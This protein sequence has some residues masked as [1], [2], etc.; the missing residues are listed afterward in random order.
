MSLL[1]RKTTRET[2]KRIID[3]L[4]DRTITYMEVARIV[5]CCDSTVK[6]IAVSAG[7]ARTAGHSRRPSA[8]AKALAERNKKVLDTIREN[9]ALNYKEIAKLIGCPFQSVQKLGKDNGLR[10]GGLANR[11]EIEAWM[12]EKYDGDRR[13]AAQRFGVSVQV[14]RAI[15]TK[16]DFT[17][18]P[19]SQGGIHL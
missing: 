1:M 6:T 3:L 4:Q 9:P 17:Q 15:V 16:L 5:G 8:K 10:D 12:L 11:A 13:Q 19:T 18:T 2:K 14:I 7:L